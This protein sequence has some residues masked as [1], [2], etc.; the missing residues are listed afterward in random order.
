MG[1]ATPAEALALARK[2]GLTVE[3]VDAVIRPGRLSNGFYETFMKWALEHDEDAHRF[4]ISNAHKDMRYLSNVAV[5]VGAVNPLQ[6]AIRNAYAAMEAAGQGD[7]YVP[8]LSDFV[9][10]ANGLGTQDR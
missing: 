1:V 3:Q 6:A 8:M 4:T 2:S 5:S 7:R 9:A 10:S